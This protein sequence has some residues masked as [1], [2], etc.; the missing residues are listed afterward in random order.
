MD[1]RTRR[2]AFREKA[3]LRV[4]WKDRRAG[5]MRKIG[6]RS[7]FSQ[8]VTSCRGATAAATMNTGKKNENFTSLL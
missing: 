8:Q 7:K 4:F 5:Y 2:G 6:N 1:S 3:G